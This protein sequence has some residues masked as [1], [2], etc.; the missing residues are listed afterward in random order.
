M[1]PEWGFPFIP[2]F[3]EVNATQF[4]ASWTDGAMVQEREATALAGVPTLRKGGP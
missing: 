4:G 1:R 3:P 2:S